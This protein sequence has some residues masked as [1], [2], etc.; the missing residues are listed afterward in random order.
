MASS[1]PNWS[2]TWRGQ[3]RWCRCCIPGCSARAGIHPVEGAGRFCALPGFDVPLAG[4]DK[5]A[6]E[7]DL[8][9]TIPYAQG[10]PTH[11]SNLKA[12]C[13]TH[14]LVKTFWGWREK[15]L[16]D[17]TL[18]LTAPTGHTY[19]TTPGSALL[20]PALCQPTGEMAA[21]QP[22]HPSTTAATAP[23]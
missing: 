1:H 8:D 2:K 17:G 15:Q 13:R 9:H 5:P 21:R 19:V 18:I 16:P 23:R 6:F 12:Y 14:H 22:T 10:G 20:F 11:A 3:P 4:C 7:C